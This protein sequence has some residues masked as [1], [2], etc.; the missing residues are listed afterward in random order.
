MSDFIASDELFRRI[1]AAI[2]AE[3]SVVN[4]LLHETLVLACSEGLAG[5]NL[6]F[7]NL[8]AQVDF[9]CKKHRVSVGDTIAIQRMR[10]ASNRSES[11]SHE[12]L[13]YACRALAVFISAVFDADIP[14][15]LVG[16]LPVEDK[17]QDYN[18]IDYRCVRGLVNEVT[19]DSFTVNI[20][21]DTTEKQLTIR[22]KPHQSYLKTLL[23]AGAQVNLIDVDSA[24]EASLIVYEPDFLLDI[25][26]I[27][28]CF[29]DYGHHPFSYL[30]N[31]ML[32]PAN[33]Q[34]ILLGNF[35]GT[36]LDDIINGNGR[37]LWQETFKKNFKD[38]AL[39]YCTCDD[40]NR[41][42]DFRAA[43]LRQ[44][45]N[46]QDIV[47]ELFGDLHSDSKKPHK[48]GSFSREKAVLEPSFVCE[49]LG[50][51]G[52][53]DLMTTDFKLL[54]E[55]KAGSN[56][57]IQSQKPNEY[58][59]FQ[60]EE[61][62]V[63]L[64]LYYGVLR[65]NF[66]ISSHNIDMRLL[67]SKYPLPGGLVVVNFYQ[68]LFREAIRL[69]NRIVANEFGFALN[70]FEGTT[71][72]LSA[73]ILNE[74]HLATP[75]FFNY[76]QPRLDSVIEPLHRLTPLEKA[77]YERMMTFVFR[78]Q[79]AAKTGAQ[80][81]LGNSMADLWNM[82][83]AVKKETGNIYTGLTIAQKA[84]SKQLNGYD[85]IT[86][87]VPDQGEDFLPNFR[88]GDMVYLYSYSPS[89]EPDVRKALLFKGNLIEIHTDRV[90]IKTVNPIPKAGNVWAIEHSGSDIAATSAIR[91]LHQFVSSAPS[92]R[93]LLLAQRAPE[94]D[95]AVQL[96]R[97]YHPT[98]DPLLLKAF[99]AKDYFL[100]V[101]PPGTGK[102]SMA[103]QF[104]VREALAKRQSILLMSYTN[105]AVDEICGMLSDNAIDYIRIGN[106]YSCDKRYRSHLLTEYIEQHPN[107]NHIRL[108]LQS[109]QV[110]VG[111]TS[112]LQSKTYLFELKSFSMTIIDEAS[113][114]LEPHL[115]GLLSRL[116]KFVL[117]GDHKQLPAV[118]QQEPNVSAVHDKQLNNIGLTN[119]R[120]SLFERLIHVEEAAERSHFVGVLQ[121]QGRMHPAI[122]AFPNR[123]FY[124]KERLKPVPLP[125]Q[126]E[127][128]LDYT[129]PS[130]D[131]LD[132]ALKSHRVLFI[133][134]EFSGNP[135]VSDKVNPHEARLVAR[136]LGRIHR[137]Y[138]ERFDADKTVGVIVPY[139]NQIAM[140]RKEIEKMGIKALEQISIDTVER[141]QGSQ[142]DVI[143]YSFTVRHRYQ[144]GFLTANCFEENG[145]I[146][147]RKL[148]V[149]ITRARR[150]LILTGNEKLLKQ[151]RIFKELIETSPS[152]ALPEEGNGMPLR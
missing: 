100:L 117:I 125:H 38:K 21:Q 143:I 36:A 40:L 45:Q 6:A 127:E 33:S 150:Q 116:P 123:M 119:C 95:A 7:G 99:Q 106:P 112:T 44:T 2:S 23:H 80:E 75:F 49:Q 83:L 129:L 144:L 148:N 120:N 109:S 135:Q 72:A 145:H 111:T 71:E 69:R 73:D 132:D 90:T 51:Q 136:L 12:E 151:D 79:L 61:H 141:Y 84:K 29:T 140:I 114:I 5:S 149:A 10:R 53:V 104:M 30:V 110:I 27:A 113:Q 18:H 134:S 52:R 115:V 96:T 55:Q 133:P 85:I 131:A 138:A 65:Q 93:Q 14:A 105:R 87:N 147:D 25:S 42:E 70:G 108:Q 67:Y 124:F 8:F 97:S 54:V 22:L 82:P 121:S 139:R 77:Y 58:G 130:I 142:R 57:N 98:Y 81:G 60:K 103:L 91:S 50:L 34:A 15:F 146:I 102:T 66:R 24:Q 41:K 89:E 31:A 107:L 35:A 26:S 47:T 92:C 13:M 11:L 76:I 126:L 9:L 68:K 48:A 63:Q 43:A 16:K 64:L 94:L 17:P 46:I 118:V 62:Y 86:L 1:E 56:Y 137:F 78:E 28:R 37:Y 4:K 152:I 74:R 20:D 19:D 32:P 3:T 101:G 59:S 39:E 128:Q 88:L 122:A